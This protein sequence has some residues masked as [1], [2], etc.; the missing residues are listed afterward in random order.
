MWDYKQHLTFELNWFRLRESQH[1]CKRGKYTMTLVDTTLVQGLDVR[2]VGSVV[3]AIASPFFFSWLLTSWQSRRTLALAARAAP[4]EKRPPTL[5][6][7]VPLVGHI[8]Q[9]MKDGHGFLSSA[10]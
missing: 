2:A 7:A 8:A 5:P 1:C 6:T 10:V 9:F 3:L 4:G